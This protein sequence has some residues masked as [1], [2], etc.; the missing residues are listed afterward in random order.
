MLSL[1]SVRPE[2]AEATLDRSQYVALFTDPE[3]LARVAHHWLASIT[4]AGVALLL[5]AS[6]SGPQ[7]QSKT[8]SPWSDWTATF[9]AR[10]ALF[11]TALQLPTGIWLLFASP[12]KAQSQLLGG[13]ISTTVVFAMAIFAMVLL[14]QNLAIGALGDNSRS[15]PVKA[16]ALLVLVLFLMSYVLH[17]TRDQ[18]DADPQRVRT[19]AF[20]RIKKGA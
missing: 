8:H 11:A 5:L 7:S 2:L 14:L 6:R 13:E 12:A 10:V 3:T 4:A 20:P 17:R 1:M 9:A 15:T 16:A 18:L 19:M